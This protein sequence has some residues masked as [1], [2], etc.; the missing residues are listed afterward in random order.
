MQPIFRIMDDLGRVV[1]PKQLRDR[2]GLS[3]GTPIAIDTEGDTVTLK[4][5]AICCKLCGAEEGICQEWDIC[6]SCA[7]RIQDA[8]RITP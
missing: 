6:A 5:R 4:R 7:K 8:P 1:I 3:A 2:L